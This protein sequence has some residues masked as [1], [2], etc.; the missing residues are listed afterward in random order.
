[1]ALL[2][3]LVARV[4][5]L[6]DNLMK[7]IKVK[8]T[9]GIISLFTRLCSYG[10]MNVELKNSSLPCKSCDSLLVENNIVRGETLEFANDVSTLLRK[11]EELKSSIVCLID[12]INLLKSNASMPCNSCV[13]LNDELD[14][15]RSKFCC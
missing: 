3:L 5:D 9:Q 15:S 1:M 11:N 12:E 7:R 13:S 6:Q 14:M 2:R 4:E 8:L 10:E